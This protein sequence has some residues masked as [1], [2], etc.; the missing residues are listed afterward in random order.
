M[1]LLLSAVAGRAAPTQADDTERMRK[2]QQ[3]L[4]KTMALYDRV[5]A[6]FSSEAIRVS[7]AGTKAECEWWRDGDNIRATRKI[8]NPPGEEPATWND[9]H[10]LREGVL[11]TVTEM[12]FWRKNMH[13]PEDRQYANIQTGDR[14]KFPGGDLWNATL[15]SAGDS[16]GLWKGF[17]ALSTYEHRLAPSLREFDGP[18][19]ESHR[20]Q[21]PA[22]TL[23]VYLDPT[24]DYLPK[25]LLAYNYPG[26]FDPNKRHAELEVVDY[27]TRAEG[28]PSA[29]PKK[30][31]ARFYGESGASR[32]PN[33]ETTYTISCVRVPD[34]M[35]EA[36]F[37]IKIPEGYPVVDFIMAKHY[38]MGP[39]GEPIPGTLR[40]L[41]AR[42]RR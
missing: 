41:P 16:L 21:D 19:I 39:D 25:K 18:G 40:D 6:K 2:A 37:R 27:F 42:L 38:I 24:H 26:R 13:R 15:L 31:R 7:G 36:V 28:L 30:I 23:I 35:P 29:F 3:A 9:E 17:W 11:T 5:Y 4:E 22:H 34:S 14:K 33:I 12:D 1:I 32:P 10:A 20:K 8:V